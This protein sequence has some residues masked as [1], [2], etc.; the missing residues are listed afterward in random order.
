M[1]MQCVPKG[2]V[3]LQCILNGEFWYYANH[4]V[5]THQQ[6]PRSGVKSQA[7]PVRARRYACIAPSVFARPVLE[8]SASA[9]TDLGI[10]R[11][12]RPHSR[13]RQATT[14]TV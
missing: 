10:D 6:A 1:T 13:A 7:P 3:P 2:H 8:L 9:A 12:R 14:T 5:L 11:V 4:V